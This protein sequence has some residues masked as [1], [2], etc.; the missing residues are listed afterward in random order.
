ME[1]SV[2]SIIHVVLGKR[3][4]KQRGICFFTFC[5]FGHFNNGVHTELRKFIHVVNICDTLDTETLNR[6]A[7]MKDGNPIFTRRSVRINS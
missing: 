2:Q 4:L 6:S 3:V 7:S 5:E 1:N